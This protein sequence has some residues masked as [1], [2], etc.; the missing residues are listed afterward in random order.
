MNILDRN[1]KQK[2]H[3]VYV[4]S[5]PISISSVVRYIFSFGFCFFCVYRSKRSEIIVFSFQFIAKK[6]WFRTTKDFLFFIFLH[7]RTWNEFFAFSIIHPILKCV[8]NVICYTNYLSNT[9]IVMEQKT[10]KRKF[11]E[12]EERR[13]WN[14]WEW[15][16]GIFFCSLWIGNKIRG[17][18]CSMLT[19]FS[20]SMSVF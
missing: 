6:K 2:M 10:E 8:N 20:V 1:S 18:F 7:K 12:K 19:H 14:N 3:S 4:Y 9:W 16:D 11:I 13:R 5:I 17:C 15:C